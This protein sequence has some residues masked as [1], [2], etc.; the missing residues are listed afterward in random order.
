MKAALH[1]HRH[2][3]GA[4]IRPC[5]VTP[6]PITGVIIPSKVHLYKAGGERDSKWENQSRTPKEPPPCP[7]TSHDY[8][9][10]VSALLFRCKTHHH[11][12]PGE[13]LWITFQTNKT[14]R[15]KVG[16]IMGCSGKAVADHTGLIMG[17]LREESN[18]GQGRCLA[19]L[20]RKKSGKRGIQE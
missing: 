10:R 4:Q 14:C 6:R 13:T 17:F 20:R 15:L 7:V 5:W 19:D 2:S 8:P 12:W 9:S 3:G 11:E 18:M 1:T 16:H